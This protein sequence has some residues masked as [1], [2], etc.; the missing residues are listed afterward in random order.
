MDNT[1]ERIKQNRE[2]GRIKRTKTVEECIVDARDNHGLTV[3]QICEGCGNIYPTTLAYWRKHNRIK[4]P[5]QE[6]LFLKV[7]RQT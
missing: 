2:A 4:D 6:R 1:S 5:D 3:R 7:T